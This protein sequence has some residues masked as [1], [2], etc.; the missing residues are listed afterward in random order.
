MRVSVTTSM[1][2]VTSTFPVFALATTPDGSASVTLWT[3]SRVAPEIGTGA[4]SASVSCASWSASPSTDTTSGLV[5]T[6]A[7]RK[8]GAGVP[9][10]TGF[11]G[12]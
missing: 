5:S 4:V 10:T 11:T 8:P 3:T 6:E 12:Q 7:M 2:T 9:V 1:W